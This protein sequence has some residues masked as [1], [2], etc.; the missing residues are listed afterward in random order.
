MQNT[1]G[2]VRSL[3]SDPL[4]L[5]KAPTH[6]PQAQLVIE[7]GTD[8]SMRH[9]MEPLQRVVGVEGYARGIAHQQQENNVGIW[10][11]NRG[12][13]LHLVEGEIAVVGKVY[14]ACEWLRGPLQDF[15]S[16]EFQWW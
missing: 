13:L 4:A 6:D 1:N 16:I 2:D 15:P 3:L 12:T 10:R 9:C 11:Q 7:D 5:V 8:R 14:P